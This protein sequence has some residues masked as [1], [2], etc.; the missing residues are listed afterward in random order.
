[1]GNNGF[2]QFTRLGRP[3]SSPL[4]AG[5]SQPRPN[6]EQEQQA[7]FSGRPTTSCDPENPY[8]TSLVTSRA[9]DLRVSTSA[10]ATNS[11]VQSSPATENLTNPSFLTETTVGQPI[12]QSS[13]AS[14][15]AITDPIEDPFAA[16]ATYQLTS[17][18]E[19]QPQLFSGFGI[20]D[21]FSVIFPEELE[22]APSTS[23]PDAS[24]E[25]TTEQTSHLSRS[26]LEEILE[27]LLGV[28]QET[29][30]FSRRDNNPPASYQGHASAPV[31]S[32][33]A[34]SGISLSS[35]RPDVGSFP[36]SPRPLVIGLVNTWMSKEGPYDKY[37]LRTDS[38]QRPYMCGFP[39]C[40]KTYKSSGHLR[41]HIFKHT[42]VSEYRCTYPECGPA[43]YFCS[44]ATLRRHIETTHENWTCVICYRG[45]NS[46]EILKAHLANEHFD[47]QSLKE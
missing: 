38:R 22:A 7:T 42:K 14:G 10:T 33:M 44:N 27:E 5:E 18:G 20:S 2:S 17:F 45:F 15:S 6:G 41:L 28:P 13:T 21:D 37:L 35:V 9:V 43:R 39:D 24:M 3:A 40:G 25:K 11:T 31:P 32:V 36:P 26:F 23:Q 30:Q 16:L 12:T 19:E 29:Q 47:H 34:A 8:L 1:M 4:N 46:R